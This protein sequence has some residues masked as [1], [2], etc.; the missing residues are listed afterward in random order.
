MRKITIG[1]NFGDA[2]VGY[3]AS[4]MNFHN[5]KYGTSYV[6][7][8]IV[9]CDLGL[10]WNCTDQ[11]TL[12]RVYE[13]THSEFHTAIAPIG[14]AV[15][16]VRSLS[17]Q[18]TFVIVTARDKQLEIPTFELLKKHFEY[19]IKNVHFQYM[20]GINVLGT[21]GDVCI[22]VGVNVFIEDSLKNA[23]NISRAGIPVLLLDAPWN[24]YDV[25]PKNI[26][27][28]FSWEQI[29]REIEGVDSF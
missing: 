10:L 11:E 25:L 24:Q 7:D 20:Q 8:Q 13:F 23:L 22:K 1:T 4:L 6:R 27:R 3:T 28:V 19:N 12:R 14:G 9:S 21:K 29:L 16:A 26:R 18:H 15:E 5:E 2:L 17:K